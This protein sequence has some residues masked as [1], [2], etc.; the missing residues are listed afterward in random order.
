MDLAQKV[1]PFSIEVQK[2]YA[3]NTVFD[4]KKQYLWRRIF[5]LISGKGGR[6]SYLATRDGCLLEQQEQEQQ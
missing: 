6:I 4:P 5:Q 2:N 3:Y 1:L